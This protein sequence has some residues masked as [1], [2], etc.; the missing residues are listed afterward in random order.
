MEW[1]SLELKR[2]VGVVMKYKYR[3]R[4]TD[5]AAGLFKSLAIMVAC[6]VLL[7]AVGGVRT[8]SADLPGTWSVS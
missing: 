1:P 3:W 8:A 7:Y 6:F 2:R 4:I 5:L